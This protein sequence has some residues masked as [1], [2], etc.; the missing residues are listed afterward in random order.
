MRWVLLSIGGL[1]AFLLAAPAPAATIVIYADPMTLERRTV[2][3]NTDG[4]DR[5][6]LCMMPPAVAGCQAIPLKRQKR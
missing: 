3:F 1:G 4:P 6:F 5:A 2:V